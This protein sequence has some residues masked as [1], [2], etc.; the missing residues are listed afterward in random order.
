MTNDTLQQTYNSYLDAY[1][2]I[3]VDERGRL[4]RQS[5]T[6]DV[7]FTNPSGE[8]QGFGKLMEHIEEF[9]KQRKGASFKSNKLL[10]HHGQFLSEWT[11]Y[12][13]D[14]SALATAHTYGRFNEQGLLT[15]LI[16]FF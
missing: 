7:V 10:A 5:V 14:G 6:D 16:G 2:D 1:N 15:Y 3:A 13:K 4:L 11:M 9:Q 12:D 8:S